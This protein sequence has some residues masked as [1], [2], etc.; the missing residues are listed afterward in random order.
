MYRDAAQGDS[1]TIS[2]WLVFKAMRPEQNRYQRILLL[3]SKPILNNPKVG[4]S[5][6]SELENMA[7]AQRS[8]MAFYF[9]PLNLKVA[10]TYPPDVGSRGQGQACSLGLAF[11]A[12]HLQRKH[13]R[14][15]AWYV[16]GVQEVP[17]GTCTRVQG[18]HTF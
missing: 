18:L 4:I 13:R 6:I 1:G 2:R 17:A 10:L 16:H 3:I 7:E 5:G 12:D 9:L 15:A 14:R 11:S 8:N